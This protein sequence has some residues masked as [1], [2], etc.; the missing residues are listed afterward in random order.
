MET[1]TLF[2]T[3]ISKKFNRFGAKHTNSAFMPN[4]PIVKQLLLI[5]PL[6]LFVLSAHTQQKSLSVKKQL[7]YTTY[8]Q[9][10]ELKEGVL[11][12]RLKTS[13]NSIEALRKVGKE[14]KA[15]RLEEKQKQTNE[16][17]VAAFQEKYDF[18][19][20]HFFF[21]DDSKHVRS[22]EW[23]QITFLNDH[24]LPDTTVQLKDLDVFTAEFGYL[25]PQENTYFSNY[26]RVPG[27]T[28]STKRK[29][30]Y[31][32]VDFG[33]SAL[34]LMDQQLVQLIEPFPYYSKSS[35]SFTSREG[36]YS[37]VANLNNRLK[38]FHKKVNRKLTRSK[39]K[40]EIYESVHK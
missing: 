40:K 19:P 17:I 38:R 32:G 20:V 8:H 10:N 25:Q 18:S 39:R 28:S 24:L 12:V 30:Y 21:S 29:R 16:A 35:I 13:K 15:N 36:A 14:K 1:S 34:L 2:L 27:D 5:L 31:G 3:T 9:I 7:K 37:E 33:F 26:Y 6:L 11:L 4:S 22:G 23:Q